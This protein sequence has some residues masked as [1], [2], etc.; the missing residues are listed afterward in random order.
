MTASASMNCDVLVVGGGPVGLTTALELAHFGCRTMLVERNPS[1]TSHPKMDLT[2]GRSMELMRRTGLA[3]KVR[4]AGVPATSNYDVLWLSDLKPNS[5]ILHRFGYDCA[6]HEYWRRRTI[7]DGTLTLEEPLRVSQIVIE[8]IIRKAAEE[9]DNTDI[10]F[11]WALEDFDQDEEGVTSRIRCVE[12][13]EI[14]TVRSRFLVGCDGGNSTVRAKL[15]VPVE[16]ERNVVNAYLVHFRSTDSKV[17]RQFGQAWHYQTEWGG[18]IGQNDVDEWTLHVFFLPPDTDY[19]K[20]DPRKVVVEGFG[21]DF[22]FEVL[23]A[24]PWSANYLITQQYSVGNV[25]MAGDAC[26]QYMPT[27]GY[28]MNTGIAEVGNLTWKLA[29]A[30]HGWGGKTLL[31]SYHQERFP[32]ANLSLQTS[33]RHLGV[34]FAI[35]QMYAETKD[36]HGDSESAK[37]NRLRFGRQIADLGNGE[38]EAWGTEH[39]YRYAGSPILVEDGG[40]PP[41]FDEFDYRPS[42]FPGC[43]LPSLFLQDGSAVYD[44][45]GQWFTLI[46]LNGTDTAS[47][48]TA[49]AKAGV[50]L[51]IVRLDSDHARKV[52]EKPLILV[53]PDH[54]VAWRGEALPGDCQAL[55]KTVAGQA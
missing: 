18:M 46:V 36:I 51:S 35:A 38:N 11:G 41:E 52:Y 27:G 48:E 29:A 6:E 55:V 54:H 21:Q 22:D 4:A 2:N 33:K 26:H 32:I 3:D 17:L 31:D 9:H 50:P 20:L 7:N 13:G 45:L 15:D 49:A 40:T 44:H 16:G 30:V 39:G 37:A 42:A 28:G 47:I 10:R 14:R 53:R 8:P 34:R 1:T 5:H 23:V 43:R 19:S 25:F 24:N 12:T